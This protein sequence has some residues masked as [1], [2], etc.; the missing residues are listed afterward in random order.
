MTDLQKAII[1]AA[2]E[3]LETPFKHQGRIPGVALD[4]A[5][6]GCHVMDSLGLPYL[7]QVGY[8]RVPFK[9]QLEDTMEKQPHLEEVYDNSQAGDIF[10]MRFGRDPQHIA[11]YTDAGTIIHSWQAA[12]KCCEHD[13]TPEWKRRIVR[14]YRIVGEL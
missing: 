1:A 12:E 10:L 8:P 2:R 3:C 6:L 14:T 5:G 9:G 7:D 11:I 4:C 13:L